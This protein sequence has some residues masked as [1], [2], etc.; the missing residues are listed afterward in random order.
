[1]TTAECIHGLELGD[2]EVCA[3]REAPEPRRQAPRASARSRIAAGTPKPATASVRSTDPRRYLVLPIDELEDVLEAGPLGE[4]EGWR[5]ELGA[6]TS[7]E[8][9]VL[10]SALA[11]PDAIVLLGVANEP[12]RRRVA[13]ALKAASRSARIVV[14]PAWFA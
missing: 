8:H 9:V 13:D 4:A 2:C 3:P 5:L 1:V 10:V 11:D 7:R 14:N 12:A 6:P